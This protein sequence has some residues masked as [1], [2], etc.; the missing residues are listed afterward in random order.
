LKVI[1]FWMFRSSPG[2]NEHPIRDTELRNGFYN[3]LQ[4]G[5][6]LGS[7]KRVEIG[8]E[9]ATKEHLLGG[10]G[11]DHLTEHNISQF[12]RRWTG[13]QVALKSRQAHDR[14]LWSYIKY[15]FC[16]GHTEG[17]QIAF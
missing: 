4:D 15:Y 6:T 2:T 8:H 14:R 17:K 12:S 16:S 1:E 3:F 7:Y 9:G 11:A 5:P 13:F 10:Y